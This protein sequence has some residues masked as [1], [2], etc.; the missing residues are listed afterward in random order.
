MSK[1]DEI[2]Y[3]MLDAYQMACV[4]A[5][6]VSEIMDKGSVG[7]EYITLIA[8]RPIIQWRDFNEHAIVREIEIGVSNPTCMQISRAFNFL[9]GD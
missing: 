4:H 8:Q 1:V 7:R 3:Y 2:K 5:C 6:F 9:V